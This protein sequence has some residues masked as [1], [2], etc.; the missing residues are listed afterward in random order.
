MAIKKGSLNVGSGPDPELTLSGDASGS[1][2][3]TDLGDATL[4]VTVA[5][6][7]HIH[8]TRYYTETEADTLLSGKSD[9]S[10]SHSSF[11]GDVAFDTNTL[12]VDA[13]NN[14][15]GIG[16][17]SP[18]TTLDVEGAIEGHAISTST[19]AVLNLKA[20]YSQ[21]QLT[22]TDDSTF[23]HYS[24]SGGKLR[25]R[26]NDYSAN[27]FFTLD[28]P[29]QRVGIGTG[30]PAENLDVSGANNDVSLLLRSG[31]VSN[32]ANGGK[33][34]V[35][36]YAGT[37]NYAHNIRTRHNGGAQ[38][39]NSIDFY[40]WNYGTDSLSAYGT[41]HVMTLDGNGNVGIG[42]TSPSAELD[43]KGASNPEIR[44]QSTDSSDPFLYFGDQVDAVRGGIGYDT[45]A[46]TL[47]LRGYNNS[48]RLAINSSGYVGINT[49][50]PQVPLHVYKSD[51]GFT[52]NTDYDMLILEN[53]TSS[54]GP[55]LQLVGPTNGLAEIAFSDTA[56]NHAQI[57]YNFS[58]NEMHFKVNAATRLWINSTGI[59]HPEGNGTQSLGASTRRWA[60]VWAV[61]TSINSSDQ[62]DKS[63]ILD[64]DYGLEFINS[65]R[66]VT[67][68]WDD[69]SGFAGVR[70]HMGF[71][72][73]E[74][75]AVMGEE[76]SNR[77]L[78]VSA[79]AVDR[80][81]PETESIVTDPDVQALRYGELM[82]P[83]VKAIQELTA[84]IEAL[85]AN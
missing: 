41:K 29:N 72:A 1:V 53:G 27:E 26:Y 55:V 6:D 19:D 13:T 28:G 84:R 17:A 77:G 25:H 59:V 50:S 73:Q 51:V 22:D 32:G 46:N 64:I 35:L 71:I 80:F 30:S 60:D 11:S 36:G 42:T 2:E 79:P 37:A 75:A 44:L 38:D 39:G 68:T 82:A 24:Y 85:E 61:D 18:A 5:D 65:L 3:F 14:R 66:P 49:T 58:T 33:Q 57:N 43:I 34:I 9:T 56:R 40:T 83:M 70:K 15:V 52:P 45:S 78:W 21:L 10:H 69:R 63:N 74:V 48:T 16:T 7:S 12:Y 81:D 67:Y 8:D 31:D 47:Q 76:A 62:R 54:R 23:I 20:S 4:S